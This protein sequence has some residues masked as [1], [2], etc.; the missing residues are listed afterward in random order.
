MDNYNFLGMSNEKR[1]DS[2]CPTRV[3]VKIGEEDK[4]ELLYSLSSML[5]NKPIEK[6]IETSVKPYT[7]PKNSSEQEEFYKTLINASVYGDYVKKTTLLP[8]LFIDK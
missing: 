7:G 6:S 1:Q 3:T 8:G 5:T 4:R 2:S